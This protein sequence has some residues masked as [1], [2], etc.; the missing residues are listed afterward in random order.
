M[1]NHVTLIEFKHKKIISIHFFDTI[2]KL[3]NYFKGKCHE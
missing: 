1:P 3:N 2:K